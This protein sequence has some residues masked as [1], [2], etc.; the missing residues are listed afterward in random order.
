MTYSLLAEG[1]TASYK[2]V[3]GD[4]GRT[5]VLKSGHEVRLDD[6]AAILSDAGDACDAIAFFLRWKM[7]GWPYLGGWAEQPARLFEIVEL[8]DPLDRLYHPRMI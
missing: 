7:M 3:Y 4:P 1:Y 5:T 8:L 6:I 2:R